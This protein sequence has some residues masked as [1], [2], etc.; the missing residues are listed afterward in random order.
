VATFLAPA[1][2]NLS[3]RVLG[4]RADGYHELETLMVPLSLF[5]TLT[6]DLTGEGGLHFSCDDPSLPNDSRNL[7]VRAVEHFCGGFGIVPN[8][9]VRL[10][11][12]IPHGAGLGGGSS[13]AATV[14][15]ALNH[16]YETGLSVGELAALAAELGSDVPF[17]VHHSAAWCRGRGELVEA[18]VVPRGIPLLLIKPPFGIP[19]P[20]AYSRWSDSKE[21]SDIPK[22]PQHAYG[23]EFVN[24]LERPVFE[25]YILLAELKRWLLSL[26]EMVAAA[27]LA[28]SGSTMFAVLRDHAAAPPL[29]AEVLGTF[30]TELWLAAVETV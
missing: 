27:L 7:A 6:I 17:F 30:G 24:D 18:T 28:G 11:K 21:L 8:I 16:L 3:L 14:L 1:K 23:I 4:K 5:D 13:D 12:A 20:W 15:I 29:A 19:T 22:D 10:A 26:E 25:K 2:V 9:D